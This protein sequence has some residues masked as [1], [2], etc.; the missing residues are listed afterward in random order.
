MSIPHIAQHART[1]HTL[2]AYRTP[3]ST[4]AAYAIPYRTSRTCVEHEATQSVPPPYDHREIKR[5]TAH[6][7]YNSSSMHLISAPR[8]FVIVIVTV[9]SDQLGFGIPIKMALPASANSESHVIPPA[10]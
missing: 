1:Q 10:W 9:G 3:H 7:Q 4:I 6:F 5:I 2:C 8:L